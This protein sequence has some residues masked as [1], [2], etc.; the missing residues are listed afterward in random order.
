[1]HQQTAISTIGLFFVCAGH[2][3]AQPAEHTAGTLFQR[4]GSSLEDANT[5]HA[6]SP[7]L[8]G[9]IHTTRGVFDPLKSFPFAQTDPS[10]PDAQV[11]GIVQFDARV[12]LDHIELAEQAGFDVGGYFPDNAII[13]RGTPGELAGVSALEGVRW[14]GPMPREIKTNADF[15]PA[16]AELSG[17]HGYM[18]QL[19][20]DSDEQHA[21]AAV[22]LSDV[23][24]VEFRRGPGRLVFARLTPAQADVVAAS[25]AIVGATRVIPREELF[26]GNGRVVSGAAWLAEPAIG[27]FRGQDVRGEIL[28]LRIYEHPAVDFVPGS[29]TEVMLRH[30]NSIVTPPDPSS[31]S[32]DPSEEHGTLVFGI[33]FGDGTCG[34]G[35]PGESLTGFL[36]EGQG[37]FASVYGVTA[38]G[39][40]YD[41]HT[42]ELVDPAGPYRAVFQNLSGTR[43][44]ETALVNQTAFDTDLVMI[45]AH[46]NFG[47]QYLSTEGR[48]KNAVTVSGYDRGITDERTDDAFWSGSSF[49]PP[50][51]GRIK[52][53]LIDVASGTTMSGEIGIRTTG[54]AGTDYTCRFEPGTSGAA[55]MT[56][57][58]F[59]LLF[60]I[61]AT[62][63][64]S[65]SGENI[66]GHTLVPGGV[67]ENRLSSAGARAAMINTAFQYD[68]VSGSP[69]NQSFVRNKQGWGA[70]DIGTLY[71]SALWD[72]IEIVDEADPLPAPS[73]GVVHLNSYSQA[74]LATDEALHVTVVYSDP[75]GVG[76]GRVNNLDLRVTAPDGTVY[77]GNQGLDAGIWS[78]S[79]GSADDVNVVENVRIENPQS[80]TWTIDVIGTEITA[81]G[82][83]ALPSDCDP[84]T[85]PNDGV[86][87]AD[88]GLVVRRGYCIADFD[89]NGLVDHT[90]VTAMQTAFLALHPKADLD[91]S[92]TWDLTDLTRFIQSYNAGCP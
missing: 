10:E 15:R 42:C 58:Q 33:A 9:L 50:P 4:M 3:L 79:G 69:A 61:W 30:T 2:A 76:N 64:P 19:L 32:W 54:F 84:I 36:P 53:D 14:A 71:E 63:E 37:I 45:Y 57:G 74:V 17:T 31:G 75:P 11:L 70:T 48:A 49:G 27:G 26:T 38:F 41:V 83:R 81:D 28:D 21:V 62:E 6:E 35:A 1:M 18:F 55:P 88:Y 44:Y 47:S 85:V 34:A 78:T 56:A 13:V 25:P 82:R 23:G 39:T 8:S 59:G 40:S 68:W 5:L 7:P 22:L 43:G 67:F 80:G 65:L 16:D 60:Q 24:A 20:I 52:P 46:G 87:D 90:D 92:G 91:R 51:P 89:Q 66:F 86:I 29:P 12:N 72:A 77:W 73:G